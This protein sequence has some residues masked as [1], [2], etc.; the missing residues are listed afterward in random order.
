MVKQHEPNLDMLSAYADGVLSPDAARSMAQHLEQCEVCAL[1]IQQER[2][3]LAEL[4]RLARV[5][6]PA[7]FVDAVMGRVAQHPLHHPA[8]PVPWREVARAGVAASLLLLVL[9]A[10]GVGWLIGSGALER[11]E[12][13]A[14]AAAAVG[15]ATTTLV[16]GLTGVQEMARPALALLESAG[17]T[18]WRL[19]MLTLGSNWL[20]QVV[21]LLLTISLNYAFTRMVL[22][23]QRRN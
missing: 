10:G 8:A 17:K 21:L 5:H 20:V 23:Y 9:A 3:F 19:T 12:P 1:A 6:P 15:S 18:F 2:L 22:G 11:A 7:D 14:I 16:S 4:N 13:G